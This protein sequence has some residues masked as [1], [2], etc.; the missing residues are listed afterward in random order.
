MRHEDFSNL[1]IAV[2]TMSGGLLEFYENVHAVNLLQHPAVVAE[3]IAAD[4]GAR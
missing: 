1:V 3:F 2:Q 4:L